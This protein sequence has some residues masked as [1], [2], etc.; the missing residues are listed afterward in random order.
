MSVDELFRV[1]G[2]SR[3]VRHDPG[4]IEARIYQDLQRLV[5]LRRDTPELHAQASAEAL[6]SADPRV[7]TLLRSS[8]RGELLVLANVSPHP[9]S[10]PL[11]DHWGAVH[12]LVTGEDADGQVVLSEYQVR[13]LRRR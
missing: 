6:W 8:A 11:P 2:A 3:Q 10:T 5:A 9:V 13:W 12:D 4:T 1:A 7:F